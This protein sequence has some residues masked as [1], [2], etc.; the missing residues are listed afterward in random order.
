MTTTT[1]PSAYHRRVASEK[2]AAILTAAMALFTEYGYNN[3]SLARVAELADVSKATLFKQFP[4]KDDLFEAIVT[5]YWEIGSANDM[6]PSPGEPRTGLTLIGK[7]Y[8]SL[9]ASDGMAGLFRLVIAEAPRFPEL[10]RIQFNLGKAP[11]FDKV[12]SYLELETQTGG[13]AVH[14]PTMAATQFLGMISNYVLW[15][16]MLLVDW[17]LSDEEVTHIVDEA[18]TTTLSRYL[19]STPHDPG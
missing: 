16:R 13:L 14:D 8:A 12:R 19:P 7:R 4:N 3:T 10:A 18:V 11:F 2:R 15:P 1:H 17:E 5:G 9:L 6:V